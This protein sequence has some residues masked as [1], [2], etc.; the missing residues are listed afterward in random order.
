MSVK[1][2][3]AAIAGPA[4]VA[5]ERVKF[6]GDNR[7]HLELRR[8]VDEFLKARGQRQRD[9]PRMYLKTAIILSGFVVSYAL[10]VFVAQ[11]WWQGLLCA[12]AL[13]LFTSQI[14]FNIMHDGGH[15]A[16]SDRRWINQLMAMSLD[17]IGGS[18]YLWRWKHAVF[19]HTYCNVA[20]QDADIDLGILSRLAPQQKRLSFHRWQHYYMW[21]LY[22]IM[23]MRWHFYGDFRDMVVSKIGDHRIPRPKGWD[24]AI[25]ILG[26]V[27]FFGLAFGI[28]LIFHR[29]WVVIVFYAIMATVVGLVLSVVFQLAHAVEEAAFPLP[30]EDSG[31]IENAWAIHQAETTVNFARRNS[32]LAWL[33]GGLNFQIEHHLFPR[34]CHTHYPAISE[35]VEDTCREYGVKYTAHKSLWAGVVSHFRWLRRMGVPSAT[36]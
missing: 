8:R 20:G 14:G 11:T 30:C 9:C 16:Y 36:G 17:M 24:L 32:L 28:P 10:L 21:V 27:I 34:V 3:G 1:S 5:T 26:K 22:G 4:T 25:F 23:A 12:I 6:S 33:L 35:L 31:Q 19:H 29:L 2:V 18:S 15:Q 13:G 7:F